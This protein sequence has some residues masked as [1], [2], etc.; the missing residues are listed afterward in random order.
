MRTA[1]LLTA[2]LALAACRESPLPTGSDR[3]TPRVCTP[4][5]CGRVPNGCGGQMECGP[6]PK[7]S[8]D[9]RTIPCLEAGGPG[10]D[11]LPA[12]LL[13]DRSLVD[14]PRADAPRDTSPPPTA[15]LLYRVSFEQGTTAAD[16][17]KSNVETKVGSTE[18]GGKVSAVPNPKQDA[19]NGSSTV[20]RHSVPAGYARAELS[21][22]RLPTANKLMSYR[23]SYYIP[24]AFFAK[25][26]SWDLISQWKTWPCGDHDGY[27]TQICGS[28]GIFNDLGA[29]ATEFELKFRAEPSCLNVKPAMETDAWVTFVLEIYW[30]NSMNGYARAWKNDQLIFD[31]KGFKTLFDNFKPGGCDLFWA[32]GVYANSSDGLEI[33]TDNLEI[34]E[35][36]IK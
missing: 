8:G 6:C 18:S 2:T 20:G 36:K 22:Q 28:C 31:Q 26:I 7:A 12:D 33:F 27:A 10:K 32:V 15:K 16:V 34:W 14:A 11:L 30:T 23:F 35:G 5:D 25:T 13:V 21:S 1:T 29:K 17:G 9:Y 3:C 4:C 19:R 24:K